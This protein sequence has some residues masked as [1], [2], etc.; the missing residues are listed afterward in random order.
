MFSTSK[1]KPFQI[2]T[3]VFLDPVFKL[4]L[5]MIV[6][7]GIACQKNSTSSGTASALFSPAHTPFKYEERVRGFYSVAVYPSGRLVGHANI[8][9]SENNRLFSTE[10][11]TSHLTPLTPDR[12]RDALYAAKVNRAVYLTDG[13]LF[14]A[15]SADNPIKLSGNEVVER[16]WLSPDETKVAYIVNIPSVKIPN[17]GGGY[18]YYSRNELYVVNTT[19]GN[20]AKI[21]GDNPASA[22]VYDSYEYLRIPHRIRPEFLPDMSRIVYVALPES[23]GQAELHSVRLDGTDHKILNGPL[24]AGASV[25]P[26]ESGSYSMAFIFTPDSSRVIYAIYLANTV[27]L[28]SIIPDGTGAINISGST[29]NV[30]TGYRDFTAT[31]TPDSKNV[32]FAANAANTTQP[33]L[34]QVTTQGSGLIKLSGNLT[35]LTHTTPIITS[36]STQVIFTANDAIY[37]VSIGNTQPAPLHQSLTYF[38]RQTPVMTPDESAIIYAASNISGG[39]PELFISALTPNNPVPPLKL[40]GPM[41]TDGELYSDGPDDSY[42]M[43]DPAGGRLVYRADAE[44]NSDYALYAVNFDGTGRKKI[45]PDRNHRDYTSSS[46]FGFANNKF[47]FAYDRDAWIFT[48]LY[49]YDLTTQVTTNI[50]ASWPAFVTED[51]VAD[52]LL[53]NGDGS[54]QTVVSE[55]SAYRYSAIIMMRDNG[56]SCRIEIPVDS[57]VVDMPANYLLGPGGNDLFY[58]LR[59]QGPWQFFKASTSTCQ[60]VL[61][62]GGITESLA[63]MKISPDGGNVVFSSG[64]IHAVNVNGSNPRRLSGDMVFRGSLERFNNGAFAISPDSTQV[65]YLAT[66][67]TLNVVE[68]YSAKMDGSGAVKL[69][70]PILVP[71]ISGSKGG[72]FSGSETFTPQIS[73]DSQWVVYQAMQDSANWELYKSHLDGTGK[74]KLS[75]T[76][77]GASVYTGNFEDTLKITPD[78][79]HVVYLVQENTPRLVNIYSVALN[80]ASAVPQKLNNTFASGGTVLTYETYQ[81]ELTPDSKSVIYMS[82]DSEISPS[83]LYVVNLDGTA[84]VKLNSTLAP[85]EQVQSYKLSTDGRKIVYL[86]AAIEGGKTGKISV[87]NLNGTGQSFLTNTTLAVQY[88]SLGNQPRLTSDGRVV[89]RATI[90]GI[91]GIYIMPIVGGGISRILQIP[92]NR[93]ISDFSIAPTGKRIHVVADLRLFGVYEVFRFDI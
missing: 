32:L 93:S 23:T 10:P 37:S 50:S 61:L 36:S 87:S 67:D 46:M 6:L 75:G 63:R 84:S 20:R 72:V 52:S 78:S 81:F 15:S 89:F 21:S 54:V 88:N 66:Q 35:L 92:V 26:V 16:F 2:L 62:N 22:V 41:I 59:S 12:A 29:V 28:H 85:D 31:V 56:S 83:E 80:N 8:D 51:A 38:V 1:F 53:Q 45:T 76:L 7:M 86:T 19:G 69:N 42:F 5:I 18:S 55:N 73:P 14:S 48:E 47:Y 82:R 24:A 25:G 71:I 4:T 44:V 13:E 40:S 17:A 65:L 79:S 58:T 11:G 60:S 64:G 74:M 33:G 68:L 30:H 49:A 3:W 9:A 57:F 39:K 43:V 91:D 34:Y 77:T 90:D 70:G 27:E